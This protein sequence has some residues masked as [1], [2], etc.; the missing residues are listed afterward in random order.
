LND[1]PPSVFGELEPQKYSEEAAKF[2]EN[3]DQI[4]SWRMLEL[5]LELKVLLNEG[6]GYLNGVFSRQSRWK[7]RSLVRFIGV[8]GHWVS[9]E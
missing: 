5:H 2:R 8:L 1:Y 4:W 9:E 7:H 3:R 6:D